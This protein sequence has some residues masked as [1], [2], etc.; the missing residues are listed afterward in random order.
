MQ[1]TRKAHVANCQTWV[2]YCRTQRY[3]KTP[4]WRGLHRSLTGTT[5]RCE[6][7][8]VCRRLLVEGWPNGHIH[9]RGRAGAAG[10]HLH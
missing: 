8:A 2:D 7:V 6:C 5:S 4:V 1:W 3:T 9:A 10:R